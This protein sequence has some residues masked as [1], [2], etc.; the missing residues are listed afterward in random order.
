MKKYFRSLVTRFVNYVITKAFKSSIRKGIEPL[1]KLYYRVIAS[2]SF[3]VNTRIVQVKKG[4]RKYQ[5]V[6]IE[7]PTGVIR[8][9]LKRHWEKSEFIPQVV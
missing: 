1:I 4:K 8:L 6:F 5:L 3:V 9:H 7:T 2:E